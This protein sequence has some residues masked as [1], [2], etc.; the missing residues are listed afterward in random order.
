[1]IYKFKSKATADLIL[2]GPQGDELMRLLGRDAPSPR[3]IVELAQMPAAIARL[4]AAIAE[5]ET[6]PAAQGATQD[7]DDPTA[8]DAP[9][10]ARRLPLR[11][12]L[13]PVIQM[14]ERAHAAGEP[15]VW[16]V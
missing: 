4:Q 16:G 6:L 10:A 7:D 15:V 11:T 12:R 14:L 2:L 8:A 5:E 3:G 9:A 1:V 13:W